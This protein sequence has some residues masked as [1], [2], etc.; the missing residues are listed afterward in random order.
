MTGRIWQTSGLVA[1]L[2]CGLLADCS[3]SS[4]GGSGSQPNKTYIVVPP[5]ETTPAPVP[6]K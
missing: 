2:A 5:N 3:S 1:L 6:A 4:G